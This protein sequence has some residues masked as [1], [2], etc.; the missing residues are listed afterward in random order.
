[1]M[2]QVSENEQLARKNIDFSAFEQEKFYR[3]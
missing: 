2:Q 3:D 1:M